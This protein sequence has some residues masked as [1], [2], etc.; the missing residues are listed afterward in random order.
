MRKFKLGDIVRCKAIIGN[1]GLDIL[2]IDKFYSIIGIDIYGD[3]Y[4]IDDLGNRNLFYA[5]S[6]ELASFIERD[7]TIDEILS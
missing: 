3:L 4:I 5:F 2:T 6:F 7:E 1:S